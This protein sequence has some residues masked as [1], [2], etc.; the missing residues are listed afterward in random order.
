MAIKKKSVSK[1]AVPKKSVS[2][3]T[4]QKKSNKKKIEDDPEQIDDNI[5]Y[6]V[7]DEVEYDEVEYD[8]NEIDDNSDVGDNDE[9]DDN[10]EKPIIKLTTKIRNRLKE[11]IT[12]WLDYDDKI[13]TLNEKTKKYKKN[14]KDHEESIMEL[15]SK[16]GMEE[17]KIDIRDD[18]DN[19]RS[20]V[21]RHK[22]VTK[23]SLKEDM[24]K[25][26]LMESIKNEKLVDQL[27]KK[28]ETKRPINERYY[29]KRTKGNNNV[30][31]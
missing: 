31:E 28:I 24:I 27:V 8:D 2:K 19:L 22:S 6:E 30:H 26:A 5:E 3:K 25:A 9:M 13:K 7:D 12:L 4:V 14:K 17:R 11:K 10:D 23:G 18:N 15:I 1:K 21:Y 16:L 29:L 20:R